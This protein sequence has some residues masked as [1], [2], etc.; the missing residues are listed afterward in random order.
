[1]NKIEKA[2]YDAKLHLKESEINLRLLKREIETIKNGLETLEIINQD[3]SIPN[4]LKEP[5]NK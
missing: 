1:M 5:I 4:E 3:K 2:I